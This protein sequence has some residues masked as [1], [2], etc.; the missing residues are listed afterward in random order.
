MKIGIVTLGCDKNTVDNEYLAGLLEARGHQVFRAE[1]GLA[2]DAVLINTCG[3]IE[4]AKSESLDAILGWAK[5]KT[6]RSRHFKLIVVGCLAQL[7]ADD[8]SKEIPEIDA[9]A[10]VG[11]FDQIVSLVEQTGQRDRAQQILRSSNPSVAIVRPYVR[12]ALDD[13]PYGFLKIA[14]GCDHT[15]SFC[16]IPRIKGEY[17]SVPREI[18]LDEV[19]A[20]LH[21]GCKELNLVAQDTT[22]YGMDLYPDYRLEHLLKELCALPGEFWVRLLYLSPLDMRQE[23]I[24]CIAEEEKVCKYVDLPVQHLDRRIL[25]R[26][27]RPYGPE[28]IVNVVATLRRSIPS[29]TI[30]TTLIVGFPGEGRKEFR[31][32]CDGVRK[33]QFDRLGVFEYSAEDE[34]E[35]AHYA[36]Q[37]APR[38]RKSRR[39]ALMRLQAEIADVRNRRTIGTAKRV[40][41]EQS[42][43]N[44]DVYLGRSEAEAPEVDGYI[45]CRSA[46]TLAPGQWVSV[47]ITDADAYDFKGEV[48]KPPRGYNNT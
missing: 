15:C 27:K 39:E 14:D 45:A 13:L 2:M 6:R 25:Q 5:E 34:T 7:Y 28:Q 10:G 41:I 24:Q 37:V 46:Q 40:L 17:R 36:D 3:F 35:A 38:T 44:T 23:L 9:L 43:P 42:I 29:V 8:L 33:L 32:L 48:T 4:E 19:R 12:K 31:A 30:R 1:N 47:R 20:L 21:R 26:M 11:M 18:L 22:K 16:T